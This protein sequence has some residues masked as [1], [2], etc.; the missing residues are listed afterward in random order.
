MVIRAVPPEG[1]IEEKVPEPKCRFAVEFLS[2]FPMPTL[3]KLVRGFIGHDYIMLVYGGWGAG[4]SFFVIDLVCSIAFGDLWRGRQCDPGLAV[5][6]AGEAPTSIRNRIR[7]WCLRRGKL[8]QG[9]PEPPIGVIGCAPDLLNGDDDLSELIEQIEVCQKATGLPIRCIAVDTVHSC[10]PGSKED[11]GDMGAVL[12]RARRLSD[13]F[14][15]PVVLVHH[16]GKDPGRGARGSVSI[17]ATPDVIVEV[18]ED[19][20][21]RTPIC[22]KVRDGELLELEPFVIEKVTFG[23]GTGDEVRIGV[24][25]LT[26]PKANPNDPRKA[27]AQKMRRDGDSFGAIAKALSVSK[28]TAVFWCKGA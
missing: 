13:R 15:C 27:K 25:E 28:S 10:A 17:E 22:R 7:A 16:S 2:Q 9:K 20:E 24:H 21:V 8:G 12:A 11:A 19:G 1:F 26:E 4:K 6:I 23:L 14:G 18:T 3:P 5:Y